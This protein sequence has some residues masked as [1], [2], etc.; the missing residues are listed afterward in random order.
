M[1]QVGKP[2]E[3]AGEQQKGHVGHARHQADDKHQAGGHGQG[4]AVT[5]HLRLHLLRHGFRAR[6]A[7][8]QNRHRHRQQQRRNL[9]DQA[10]T[11]GQQAVH[12]EC[13]GKAQAVGH[14]ANGHP[15]QQVDHQNQDARHGVAL[16]ELAGAVHRAVEIGLDPHFLTLGLGL[17]AGQQSGVQVGVD[18]HLLAGHRI[19]GEARR[20]LGDA[21]GA[22]GD[23]REIDD[24]ENHEHHE[25]H[26][27]IAADHEAAECFDHLAGRV[28]AL[29]AVEQ[30][31]AGR[32]HVQGQ[33]EQGGDQQHGGKHRE[34]Q[35]P[36]HVQHSQQHH[37][38]QG[39][40]EREEQVQRQRRQRHH[41]HGQQQKQ[42]QR[43]TGGL[44]APGAKVG[45]GS[46]QAW[47]HRRAR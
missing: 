35:R 14:G 22:L 43:R 17:V 37:Q 2:A 11:N 19:Q 9:R 18:G 1:Q 29:V 23:D 15:A 26:R 41:H 21:P 13:L 38:R 28:A 25:T 45:H 40:V 44:Q 4:A 8:D 34:I 7:G 24:G 27:V 3:Q 33:P 20:H 5:D 16:D 47:G 42:D 10:V 12:R 31:H 46:G 6:H 36:Q 30:H 39:D 32:G